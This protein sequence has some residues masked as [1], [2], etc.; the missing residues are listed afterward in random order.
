M[1]RPLAER[2]ARRYERRWG[3][4]DGELLTQA[5]LGAWDAA[6]RYR[7]GRGPLGAYARQRIAGAIHDEERRDGGLFRRGLWARDEHGDRVCKVWINP[8]DELLCQGDTD[9]DEDRVA[10]LAWE[11]PGYER[12]EDELWAAMILVRLGA[13]D[14]ELLERTAV[15]GETLAAL[16]QVWRPGRPLTESRM[17][18][19]RTRAAARAREVALA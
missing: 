18:Q 4:A 9:L 8:L 5:L 16:G 3:R 17:C 15:G 2:L 12:V 10:A 14:A 11:E 7:P 19:L 13:E 1:L 6:Q